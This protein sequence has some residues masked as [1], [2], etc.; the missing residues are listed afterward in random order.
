MWFWLLSII[1]CPFLQYCYSH[2]L[3]RLVLGPCFVMRHLVFFLVFNQQTKEESNV[4]F[5]LLL[6]RPFFI[7][8]FTNC[9]YSKSWE[10]I[11]FLKLYL[12][13]IHRLLIL[14]VSWIVFNFWSFVCVFLRVILLKV[15]VLPRFLEKWW[16]I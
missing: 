3:W 5:A 12:Y 6:V 7:S 16:K 10:N 11:R 2:C 8:W 13:F 4:C 1:R 15:I 14:F 9:K